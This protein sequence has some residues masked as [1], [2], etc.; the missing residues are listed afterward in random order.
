MLKSSLFF[1]R[2]QLVASHMIE[3]D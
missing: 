2:Y 1:C 3:Y